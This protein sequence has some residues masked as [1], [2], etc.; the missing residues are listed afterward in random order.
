LTITW[1]GSFVGVNPSTFVT[2]GT[3]RITRGTGIYKSWKG[4]GTFISVDRHAPP[5][6][7]D[8]QQPTGV[9][10]FEARF[11]GLWLPEGCRLHTALVDV[12]ASRAFYAAVL[13][14]LG[15][16]L[17]DGGDGWFSA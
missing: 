7:W 6:A 11:E 1:A 14:P 2:T 9:G 5:V 12:E 16:R 8:N 10:T 4:G 3:W 15:L 13:E 17:T